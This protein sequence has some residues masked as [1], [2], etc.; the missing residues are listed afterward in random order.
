[1]TNTPI[2]IATTTTEGWRNLIVRVRGGGTRARDVELR[3]DGRSY[4]SNPTVPGP[5]VE[6]TTTPQAQVVIPA[7]A[8]FEDA[9][10]LPPGDTASAPTAITA[11][12]ADSAAAPGAETAATPPVGRYASPAA[13]RT[14]SPAIAKEAPPPAAQASA[15]SAGGGPSFDCAQAALPVEKL[16]CGD[17]RL[18]ALDRALDRAYVAAM[19]R[20]PDDV[21]TSARA[22]QRAWIAQRNGCA[23]RPDATACVTASYQR[24]L[25][26]VQI[27][28]GQLE[29]PTP[30]A[31]VC[32]GPGNPEVS[33]GFYNE[34][35]P[36]SATI[37]LGDRRTIAFAVRAASGAHY[38]SAT[39]DFWEHHGEATMTWS[40]A[41]YVCRAR[42]A[43]GRPED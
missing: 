25:I 34:T 35:D 32:K 8:S 37:T 9:T 30:V 7:L 4:P 41:T 42:R 3:F 5:R 36:Q 15:P 12:A 16:I 10:L 40:G 11:P 31:Y 19:R 18:A 38:V 6:T 26:E 24:R 20:W 23:K 21:K 17:G 29:V 43:P 27:Q 33:V 39:A 22:A 28:G 2:G 14:A 1:V 13:A